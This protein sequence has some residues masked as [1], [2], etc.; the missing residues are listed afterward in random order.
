MSLKDKSL[1][2][3]ALMEQLKQIDL[4]AQEIEDRIKELQESVPDLGEFPEVCA[5]EIESEKA[6]LDILKDVCIEQLF[7][8]EPE[9]DA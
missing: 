7:D 5:D 4:T 2:F 9:G 8:Q 3:G 1:C 6:L